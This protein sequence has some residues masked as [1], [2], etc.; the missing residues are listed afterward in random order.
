MA[1]ETL[2]EVASKYAGKQET[3][4]RNDGPNIRAWKTLLG[5]GVAGAI[6][7]PWCAIFVAAMLMLR[8]GLNRRQLVAKLGFRPGSTFLES[9]D[10]WV[11]EI[12][13]HDASC[14]ASGRPDDC[15][16]V[17]VPQ[18]GDIA[19]LM[20]RD[21]RGAYSKTKAHHVFIVTEARPNCALRTIEGNTVP[22]CA[23]SKLS[24][25]GDGVYHRFR[26]IENIGE[27]YI[28]ARFPSSLTGVSSERTSDA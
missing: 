1:N 7:I 28:F 15:Y 24:R 10:S 20:E 13:A 6:G 3:F 27:R 12:I 17:Q 14:R 26:G 9:C 22:G 11:G 8:N 2:I 18:P 4:G 5:P 21:A 25:E 19:F 23:E 16:I